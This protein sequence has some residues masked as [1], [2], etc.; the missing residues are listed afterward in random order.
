MQSVYVSDH[1]WNAAVGQFGDDSPPDLMV[2]DESTGSSLMVPF[3]GTG[4]GFEK[5][6]GANEY[7]VGAKSSLIVRGDLDLDQ[8]LDL[9]VPRSDTENEFANDYVTVML[10]QS[11]WSFENT[12]VATEESPFGLQLFDVNED[13]YLDLV[14][15]HVGADGLPLATP[16]NEWPGLVG[17]EKVIIYLNDKSGGF[18]KDTEISVA[19]RLGGLALA[20]VDCDGDVDIVVPS[21]SEGTIY[22]IPSNGDGTFG[23]PE[24]LVE[25]LKLPVGVV[26]QDVNADARPD[27]LWSEVGAGRFNVM[28]HE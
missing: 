24:P 10:N 8:R 22:A 3:K 6:D 12:N 9:V 20:D 18:A 27:L 25:N 23:A 13:S 5:V 1:V 16:V 7:T 14:V 4:A 15:S 26:I 2:V 11:K 17:K 19:D 21:I 28:F